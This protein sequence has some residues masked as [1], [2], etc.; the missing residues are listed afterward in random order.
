MKKLRLGRLALVS[1][2]LLIA[3]SQLAV[4]RGKVGKVTARWTVASMR[5]EVADGVPGLDQATQ[6]LV[7]AR[8]RA[9]VAADPHFAPVPDAAPD[10]KLDPAGFSK[11]LASKKLKAFGVQIRVTRFIRKLTPIAG[12]SDQELSYTVALE[13]LGVQVPSSSLGFTGSG[14]ALVTAQVGAT[15][16]PRLDANLRQQVLDAALSK[17]LAHA[18]VEL[19]AHDKKR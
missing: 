2:L 13:L 19:E 6:D 3:A 11:A 8:T 14:D 7:I 18:V 4:A 10:P 9:A 15:I 5:V 1:L 12:S 16:S 17:G